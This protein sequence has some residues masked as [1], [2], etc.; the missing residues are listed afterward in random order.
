MTRL[1]TAC[2][3]D[4]PDGCSLEVEVVDGRLV[5][6]DA[7]PD[8]PG[9]TG[10]NPLTQGFICHKVKRHHRRVYSPQ[11]ILTPLVRWAP[12]DADEPDPFRPATWDEALDLVAGR[13]RAALDDDPA[14]VVPYLYNSSAGALGAGRLGPLL[15]EAV[16]AS[17]VDHTICAATAS[18]AWTLT[19]GG[20]TGADLLDVVH[21]QLVVVWGANPA[22]SNTHFPPLVNQARR[23]GAALVVVDPR[24]TAMA[25]RADLH[26]APRPGT[27]VVLAMATAAELDRRHLVDRTFTDA[28]AA[29]VDEY[30]EAC[31]AWS[32]RAAAEVCG[33]GVEEIDALVELLATRRP[34]FWRPGWGLERNRN[35][36]SAVRAVLA[37]PVLTGAFGRLGAGVHLHTDH[38]L[39]WDDAGLR[40]AVLGP[41][42]AAAP[43]PSRRHVNQNQLGDLL[44]DPGDRPPVQVLF[45]QG[46][47]PATMNPAQAKVLAGLA[48]PDLFTVVHE[49]VMTDTARC[50]DVVL[51]ATTHFEVDDVSVP[52]G[53]FVAEAAPAVIARVGQSRTN[54]EVTAGLAGRLGYD[55][56][57]G[58]GFDADVVRIRSR[59]LPTGPPERVVTQVAGSAVQFADR[60]PTT[61]DRRAQLVVSGLGSRVPTY[62]ELPADLPLT[63]I[64]P[65]GPDRI[66]SMF[67]EADADR[68]D[69]VDPT[70]GPPRPPAVHLHPGDAAERGL[71][72]GQAVR[73]FDQ[74]AELVTEVALDEGLRPGVVWMPKGAWRAAFGGS[75]TPNVFAPDGLSDLAGGA[76]FNDARVDVAAVG[77][78]RPPA[79]A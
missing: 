64:T 57:P 21:A 71:V 17:A 58:S 75:C 63:L 9:D 26:L 5:S 41:D 79:L 60:W 15:W 78:T 62:V 3:L 33:L 23:R 18:M 66:N 45:V 49:Q 68:A 19:F 12:K 59:V 30:L 70:D 22:I 76:T 8:A 52:Y 56:G 34:A 42:G 37:L 27:D 43:R 36:G 73:V 11:R 32:P 61:P 28:H 38:D 72:A 39:D 4:C 53:A 35:G 69:G 7:A 51:P 6:V 29:G 20:L 77:P 13:I 25:A 48:R 46:A 44:V 40:D 31:R 24:R 55:V 67:G 1:R 54:D 50:A 14:T 47:N 2:P 74:R 10:V 65:A 16:G